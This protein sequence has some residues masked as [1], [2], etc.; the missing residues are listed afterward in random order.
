[1]YSSAGYVSALHEC[2]EVNVG[3]HMRTYSVIGGS[4]YSNPHDSPYVATKSSLNL[5]VVSLYPYIWYLHCSLYHSIRVKSSHE[6][7]FS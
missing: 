5:Q 4:Q 1:M 2:P 3:G 7:L 6:S